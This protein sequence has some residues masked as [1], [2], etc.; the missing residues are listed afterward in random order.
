M[1]E[2]YSKQQEEADD[3]IMMHICHGG[4]ADVNSVM[5]YSADTDVFVS[6]L[7]HFKV[8]FDVDEL[9]V[10]TGGTKRKQRTVPIH[11][12]VDAVNPILIDC[13]PAI[14]SLTGCDTTSKIGTK[15][16]ILKKPVD[17]DLVKSFGKTE[18][19]PSMVVDAEKFLLQI[20]GQEEF[21]SFD[22]YY[23]FHQYYNSERKLTLEN[24][25]CCSSTIKIHI[26]R[27]FLQTMLWINA[28]KPCS[29]DID[30][31]LYGYKLDDEGLL[32]PV[33]AAEPIR[34]GD[35]PDPC[36]CKT[37]AKRTCKCRSKGL[38]CVLYCSCERSKCK[39]PH[40]DNEIQ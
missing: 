31:L 10:I 22:E 35:L 11:L 8:S 27:A 34:P 13:I 39:N 18:L 20:L 19:T 3:R 36:S 6:L 7:Y 14:H 38:K 24:I 40:N 17:L 37:C 33:L 15:A 29:S 25:V 16:A 30:P 26:Q 9:Y 4:V 12:L 1:P 28:P 32:K 21:K 23:R 2:L 5:V